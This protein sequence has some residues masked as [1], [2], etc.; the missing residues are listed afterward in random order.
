VLACTHV[1]ATPLQL[2]VVCRIPTG[3]GAC[4]QC[5]WKAYVSLYWRQMGREVVALALLLEW[6]GG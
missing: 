5:C 6:S 3:L 1:V 2:Q 4:R